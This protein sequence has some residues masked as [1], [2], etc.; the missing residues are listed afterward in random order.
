MGNCG[1]IS[2][3]MDNLIWKFVNMRKFERFEGKS[4]ICAYLRDII[5]LIM[6]IYGSI[7]AISQ[8]KN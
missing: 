6:R 1:E 3:E 8:L 5:Q 4:S 7:C 2:L